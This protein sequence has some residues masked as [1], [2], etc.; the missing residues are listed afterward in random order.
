LISFWPAPSAGELA[1]EKR[2]TPRD[3]NHYDISFLADYFL[4][5]RFAKNAADMSREKGTALIGFFSI[6]L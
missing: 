6:V 3:E 1:L 4:A 5:E 2:R